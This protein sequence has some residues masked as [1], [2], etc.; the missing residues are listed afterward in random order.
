MIR[1]VVFASNITLRAREVNL[2]IVFARERGG[3]IGYIGKE[4]IVAP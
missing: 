3:K 2:I 4:Q 1:T